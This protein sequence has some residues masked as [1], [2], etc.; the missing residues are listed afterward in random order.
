MQ[1]FFL[2]STSRLFMCRLCVNLGVIGVDVPLK[3]Q[4]LA[5]VVPCNLIARMHHR[6]LTH[7]Q[8]QLLSLLFKNMQC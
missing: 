2:V 7:R 1:R 5:G 8:N 6:S 3:A 4:L